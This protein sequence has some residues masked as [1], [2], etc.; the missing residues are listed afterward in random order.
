MTYEEWTSGI[1]SKVDGTWNLHHAVEAQTLDFFV[2]FSSMVG[3]CGHSGQA[4]YAAANTFLESFT[5]YRRQLGLPSSILSLGVVEEVGVVSRDLKMLQNAQFRSV[6][7]LQ[8]R[9]V[10]DGLQVAIQ[11]SQLVSDRSPSHDSSMWAIGLRYTKPLSDPTVQPMWTRDARFTGYPNLESA[12]VGKVQGEDGELRDFLDE[13]ER[14]PSILED[15]ET[16]AAPV[17]KMSKL[18]AQQLFPGIEDRQ[19]SHFVIDSLMTLEVRSWT[20]RSL[21]IEVSVAEIANA[22][23]VGG[24]ASLAIEL[25]KARYKQ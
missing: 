20:R 3:I 7:L 5:E 23:T 6:H 14:D 25:L 9:E 8:E 11:D 15:T 18:L 12:N 1:T 17:R 2:V 13:V 21:G 19:S 4:N 24:L 16:D 22:G 10:I